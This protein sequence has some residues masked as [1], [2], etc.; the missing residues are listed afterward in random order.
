MTLLGHRPPYFL[1][2]VAKPLVASRTRTAEHAQIRHVAIVAGAATRS[3][4]E[5]VWLVT[6]Q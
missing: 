3:A 1:G 5:K 2:C 6:D 4:P